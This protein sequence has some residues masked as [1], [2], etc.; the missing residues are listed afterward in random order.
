VDLRD[1]VRFSKALLIQC[2]VGDR[3]AG[4]F[5][6]PIDLA[7][8]AGSENPL[9]RVR[10]TREPWVRSP[11]R[12]PTSPRVRLYAEGH[13]TE[14]RRFPAALASHLL[15]GLARQGLKTDR[16]GQILFEPLAWRG[17]NGVRPAFRQRARKPWCT[18][19]INAASAFESPKG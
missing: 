19:Q 12:P 4:E 14:I 16:R 11:P 3:R 1:L 5:D 13:G 6:K 15:I 2:V 9:S 17:S 8:G 18:S 7:R 10:S